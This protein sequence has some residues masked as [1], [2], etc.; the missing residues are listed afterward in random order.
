MKKILFFLATYFLFFQHPLWAAPTCPLRAAKIQKMTLAVQLFPNKHLMDTTAEIDLCWPS[1]TRK[2][3]LSLT[4]M[5]VVL[6]V[7]AQDTQGH[8]KTLPFRRGLEDLTLLSSS[9]HPRPAMLR[10]RI[11]YQ[12]TFYSRKNY[13]FR[14]IF[15]QI[16][17][18]DTY[19]LYGWYPS[20]SAFADPIRG[21][22]LKG[23]RFPYTLSI[24][25]PKTELALSTGPLLGKTKHPDGTVEWRYGASRIKE[26]ALL[27][28]AGNLQ[29]EHQRIEG[30]EMKG[31]PQFQKGKPFKNKQSQ[32][33]PKT[34]VEFYL[35]PEEPRKRIEEVAQLIAKASAYYEAL[36]GLPWIKQGA[37]GKDDAR[38]S[39]WRRWRV[40]TF[41]GSGARGYP[42]TLL[43]ERRLGFLDGSLSRPMDSLFTHRHVL[44]HEIAHTWWGNAVT[45]IKAGSTWLNEGLAN[46]ASLKAIGFLYGKTAMHK[47]I[48]RHT[49]A[50]L[51][52]KWPSDLMGPGGM[53]QMIQRTA[54]T[55]G[56]LVFFALERI[57]GER[58]FLRAL[59]A[60]FQTYRA[61]FATGDDLRRIMERHAG[62]SLSTFFKETIRGDGLPWIKPP[63]WKQKGK[64]PKVKVTLHL[65]NQGDATGWL[66]VLFKGRRGRRMWK[67]FEIPRGTKTFQVDVPFRVRDIRVDPHRIT[68]QGIRPAFW[69]DQ[70]NKARKA[71]L[72]KQAEQRFVFLVRA[73]PKHGQALYSYA[74]LLETHQR[75]KEALRLY[76]RASKLRTS[77]Q[78]PAWIAPWSRFRT[79]QLLHRAGQ[80]KAAQAILQKL[81]RSKINPFHLQEEVEELL[82]KDAHPHPKPR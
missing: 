63:R 16:D 2:I 10:V 80:H 48:Q 5:A 57:M 15:C 23:E 33:L 40:A 36:W 73:F 47:A 32:A 76:K 46:Y 68:L 29:R 72:W 67:I 55:K 42:M 66:P 14:Q 39:R 12:I 52:S 8:W 24:R 45:G 21:E 58:T 65:E 54:Y 77:K 69:L 6:E 38:S 31:L 30:L 78:T 74:R 20:L 61:G 43:L 53:D 3:Q 35:R 4:Q 70:A 75:P 26:G 51:Q 13:L 1:R 44:L 28:V 64:R 56:T 59:R 7:T 22:L 9:P 25:A 71:G 81:K 62:R 37:Q 18:G 50:F 11:H 60:F 27:L 79:A 19:F 82:K 17:P 41:G 49:R 34:I